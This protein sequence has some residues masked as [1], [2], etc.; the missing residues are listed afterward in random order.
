MWAR[1]LS[2]GIVQD[3]FNDLNPQ[4]DIE[5]D[6]LHHVVGFRCQ[7]PPIAIGE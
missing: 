7:I 2:L 1:I 4:L 3:I 5:V 6:I